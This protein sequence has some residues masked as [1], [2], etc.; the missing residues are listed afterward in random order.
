MDSE[1]QFNLTS[2]LKN[3]FYFNNIDL[4]S[5][6]LTPL[7]SKK[8]REQYDQSKN[9]IWEFVA[10]QTINMWWKKFTSKSFLRYLEFKKKF[11]ALSDLG[12]QWKNIS[13]FKLRVRVINKNNPDRYDKMNITLYK[14][15]FF[16]FDFPIDFA[17]FR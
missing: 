6:K 9:G 2:H 13:Y 4:E 17:L 5:F 8:S 3:S 11:R 15:S 14:V 10:H 16:M 7:Y 1:L 12:F